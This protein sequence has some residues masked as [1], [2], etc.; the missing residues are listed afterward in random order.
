[1]ERHRDAGLLLLLTWAVAI[2]SIAAGIILKAVAA[3]AILARIAVA[4]AASGGQSQHRRWQADSSLC[5]RHGFWAWTSR[6]RCKWAVTCP[7]RHLLMGT[8][9]CKDQG[10][11]TGCRSD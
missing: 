11:A 5:C 3:I 9:L 2:V 8:S 10:L 1:M 6:Q 7:E 4:S